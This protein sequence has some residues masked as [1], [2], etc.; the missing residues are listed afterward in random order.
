MFHPFLAGKHKSSLSIVDSHRQ[1]LKAYHILN[2]LIRNHFLKVYQNLT[3]TR[4][5]NNKNKM[6]K[7]LI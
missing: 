4:H 3:L 5:Y 2:Y 6:E 1:C 7:D